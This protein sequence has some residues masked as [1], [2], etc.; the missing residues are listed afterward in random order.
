M[1]HRPKKNSFFCFL[2]IRIFNL[3][4]LAAIGIFVLLA[5]DFELFGFSNNEEKMGTQC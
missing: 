2:Q 4:Y 5:D 3:I 1:V